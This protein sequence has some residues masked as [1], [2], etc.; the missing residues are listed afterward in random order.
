M[1]PEQLLNSSTDPV[2]VSK[3]IWENPYEYH[4]TDNLC[5]IIAFSTFS[6]FF[7]ICVSQ[8]NV[9]YLVTLCT[10]LLEIN[11]VST[12]WMTKRMTNLSFYSIIMQYFSLKTNF[13]VVVPYFHQCNRQLQFAQDTYFFPT[14]SILIFLVFKAMPAFSLYFCLPFSLFY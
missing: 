3:L 8:S 7:E 12:G 6:F 4:C 14:K 1:H 9:L 5:P 2:T 11:L 10:F 13:F